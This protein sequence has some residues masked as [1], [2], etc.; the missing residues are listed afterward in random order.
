MRMMTIVFVTVI[1]ETS[2]FSIRLRRRSMYS[3]FIGI[4]SLVGKFLFPLIKEA[5]RLCVSVLLRTAVPSFFILSHPRPAVNRSRAPTEFFSCAFSFDFSKG[6]L[7]FH[8][9]LHI[10]L[11]VRE[12]GAEASVISGCKNPFFRTGERT[13]KK[14]V[15]THR[16]QAPPTKLRV[17][18]TAR[19]LS[20]L[21][22]PYSVPRRFL[23]CA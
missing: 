14:N 10:D 8:I 9:T 19:K 6:S 1:E 15:Q 21:S 23:L 13:K 2:P 11:C 22:K 4:T 20:A 3:C 17:R 5:N 18:R 7:L 16:S 12:N